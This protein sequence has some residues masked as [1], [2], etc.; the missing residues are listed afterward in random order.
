MLFFGQALRSQLR[1]L[2]MALDGSGW[3]GSTM[4]C[5]HAAATPRPSVETNLDP[6]SGIGQQ[7]RMQAG[8]E[9]MQNLAPSSSAN[10]RNGTSR[11]NGGLVK[12]SSPRLQL[13]SRVSTG[14]SR[15]TLTDANP[16]SL[17]ACGIVASLPSGSMS[18]GHRMGVSSGTWAASQSATCRAVS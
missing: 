11:L 9:S 10:L 3:E 15:V 6:I 16:A 7:L 18:A 2:L 13:G 4:F 8:R 12:I 14:R 17:A 5:I 1:Q